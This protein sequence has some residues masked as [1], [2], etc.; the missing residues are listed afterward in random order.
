MRV[1]ELVLRLEIPCPRCVM[2]THGFDDLPRDPRVM[3]A[4]VQETGGV[5][6]LYASVERGGTVRAGDAVEL[7]DG[8]A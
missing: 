8:P 7:L 5:L 4:L 2:T 6:G 3:R 1:G